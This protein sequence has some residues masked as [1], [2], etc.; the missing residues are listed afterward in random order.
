MRPG[1]LSQL[2]F[3]LLTACL[4]A[5][6]SRPIQNASTSRTIPNPIPVAEPAAVLHVIGVYQGALPASADKRAWWAKCQAAKRAAGDH[7][8]IKPNECGDFL[9]QPHV[10]RTV[11]VNISDDSSPVVLGLMSYEPATWQIELAP[12]V[13]L[14]KV[15]M[16][17]YH[18]QSVTGVGDRQIDVY[19]YERSECERCVQ[20]GGHFYSYQ[21]VPAKMEAAAGLKAKSFQGNYTGGRYVVFKGMQ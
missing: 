2:C 12:G 5:A 17:G 11:T 18:Q 19:T 9:S 1:Y 7:A 21:Q 6:C 16:A 3:L 8:A 20:K 15:I 14:R 4:S 10:Q 13:Q